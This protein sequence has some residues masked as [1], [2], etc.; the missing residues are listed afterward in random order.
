MFFCNVYTSTPISVVTYNRAFHRA[1][2]IACCHAFCC[3]SSLLRQRL[4]AF[5]RPRSPRMP[6]TAP[7]SR[8]L[9]APPHDPA[10]ASVIGQDSVN[11]LLSLNGQKSPFGS[12]FSF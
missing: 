2:S 9:P 10:A 8:P 7:L 6:L 4:R 1:H 3:A 11:K 12:V 5:R